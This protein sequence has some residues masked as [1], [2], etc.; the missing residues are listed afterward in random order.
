MNNIEIVAKEK[1]NGYATKFESKAKAQEECLGQ[2]SYCHP[3]YCRDCKCWHVVQ[4]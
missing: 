3:E 2:F 1:C 4:S